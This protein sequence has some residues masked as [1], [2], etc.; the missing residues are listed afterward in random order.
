MV[1][2]ICRVCKREY[3]FDEKQGYDKSLCGPMCDGIEAG[4][5]RVMEQMDAI[6]REATHSDDSDAT[7]N[8]IVLRIQRFRDALKA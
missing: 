1:M 6:E 7:L 8:A 4:R 2:P 3:V 5:S